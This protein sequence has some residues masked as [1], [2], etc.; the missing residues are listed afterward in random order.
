MFQ[1]SQYILYLFTQ[2]NHVFV[3][4]NTLLR[5]FIARIM[6]DDIFQIFPRCYFTSIHFQL[7][8]DF[9]YTLN[10]KTKANIKKNL[11]KFHSELLDIFIRM[12][13]RISF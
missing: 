1:K 13:E 6:E 8:R 2:S 3:C 7:L 12:S 10:N 5:D 4:D 11:Q 9:W